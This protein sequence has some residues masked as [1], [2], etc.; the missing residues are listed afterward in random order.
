MK[1]QMSLD[2]IDFMPAMELI[3]KVH[4]AIDIIEVGTPLIAIEGLR[5]VK[6]IRERYPD[7]TILADTKI[8]D[9]GEYV[10]AKAFEAG[11]D[12]VTVLAVAE[13]ATVKKVID[14]AKK[15]GKQTVVDMIATKNLSE[16]ARQADSW[17]ADYIGVHVGVDVQG[18]GKNPL[19]ELRKLTVS[20]KNAKTAVAGGVDI[21]MLHDL[22]KENPGIIICGKSIVKALSPRQMI[23]DMKRILV[24]G[25][26]GAL[27]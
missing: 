6:A 4:D 21:G 27:L 7:S 5:M 1:L 14:T 25:K 9:G 23:L 17:G 20:I 16:R 10:S 22:A 8:M 15:Y 19:E 2:K 3:E 18:L 13:D 24:E 12:F 26:Q 11:A